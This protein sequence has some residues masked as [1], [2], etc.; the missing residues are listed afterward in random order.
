MKKKKVSKIF[1]WMFF[2]PVGLYTFCGLIIFILDNKVTLDEKIM[3]GQL[4][5][6][7]SAMWIIPWFIICLITSIIIEYLKRKFKR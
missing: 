1:M 2:I 4:G 5:L 7:F 3:F 6:I